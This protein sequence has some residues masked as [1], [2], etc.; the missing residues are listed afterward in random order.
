M[1]AAVRRTR[2]HAACQRER[3]PCGGR[4]QDGPARSGA[5]GRR[6]I[7]DPVGIDAACSDDPTESVV[8]APVV[9]ADLG[10]GFLRWRR[11]VTFQAV[12]PAPIAPLVAE[13]SFIR[14]P[15]RRGAPFR[16]GFF[17]IPPADYA[18]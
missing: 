4:R 13:L 1:V 18:R 5:W 12:G 11:A 16:F 15:H 2:G 9:H 10:G 14:D 6:A 8:D 3:A 7:G 17:E